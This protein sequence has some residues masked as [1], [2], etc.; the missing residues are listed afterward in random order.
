[1]KKHTFLRAFILSAA[2]CAVMLGLSISVS[3]GEMENE[4]DV[5]VETIPNIE[6]NMK[7]TD[8]E[9]SSLKEDLIN[10]GE[11]TALDIEMELNEE[12]EPADEAKPADGAEP[13]ED[14]EVADSNTGMDPE[15]SGNTHE[16]ADAVEGS[17]IIEGIGTGSE[18]TV[19]GEEEAAETGNTDVLQAVEESIDLQEEEAVD[20][21]EK[22][23]TEEV[24]AE[25]I[26]VEAAPVRRMALRSIL[27]TV[28]KT[29]GANTASGTVSTPAEDKSEETLN[30]AET[31]KK[32]GWDEIYVNGKYTGK[33]YRDT[34][35][36]PVSG[37]KQIDG[38]WYFF[39]PET[40]IMA[41]N[42]KYIDGFW[43]FF[44]SKTGVMAQNSFVNLD[45]KT[46][47]NGGPKTCYYD[48]Q[49]HLLY[50]QRRIG[51]YW[52]MFRPGSGAMVT[53]DFY[54]HDKY[55]NPNGGPKTCYYDAQGRLQYSQKKIGNYW[56][57]FRPGSGAMVEADFYNHD[58]NTNPNG[59][60][61][62]CYYDAHGRLQYSQKRIGNYWYMF[63]P[64]SGAMVTAD[65]YKH[66]NNTNP[67][68]GP[69]TCY[70]D[71]QG[72]LQYGQKRIGS[73][74]YMFRPG[75]GAMVEGDFFTHDSNTNP[76][77]GAKTCY[78]D[79]QGHMLYGVQVI[80][81]TTC[82]FHSS[83]G[84]LLKKI[85][86][87]LSEANWQVLTNV[88][89][90]VESGGQIYGNRDYAAYAGQY[91]SSSNEHTCTLGWAQNYGANAEE[92]I[93]RIYN[94][95]PSEFKQ[96]DTT[97]AIQKMIGK[98]WVGLR[99]DP[100]PEER[101]TLIRLITTDTGKKQQDLLF[102]DGCTTMVSDCMT[103]YSE[104]PKTIMMYCEVRHQGGNGG[105]TRIMNRCMERYGA[106]NVAN[107]LKSLDDD[108]AD[109]FNNQVGDYSRR[110]HV[111]A[112]FINKYTVV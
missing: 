25:E 64:G 110:H 27:S 62:T 31:T 108:L 92:L 19:T 2:A 38:K 43:Y 59:G 36:N 47:P 91:K 40:G 93:R 77:G 102:R 104:D 76:H 22:A 88:I 48:A 94:A 74:W 17:E 63:R 112:D 52:Y 50:N 41:T 44:D 65:F 78:Y 4:S 33:I 81:G 12:P 58:K 109:G 24:T 15:A 107:I 60:P 80:D 61:K 23:V 8:Q 79:A 83:S 105:V 28:P 16:P 29:T 98:D 35:G 97:G 99:W 86:R 75:S 103:R 11:Q 89:G 67:N 20:P 87:G 45:W 72:H 90:A 13:A 37:K 49:G 26:I 6:E 7:Y 95:N 30:S 56:Y 9:D 14:A 42:Q 1:M 10:D 46:N 70:Y 53:A 101:D 66:D 85:V 106:Y 21:A 5:S 34:N 18:D 39:D 111:C 3:A 84:A 100:N 73:Y 71:A 82:E 68:G 51:N 96:I 32:T 57:M 55:T 69:K 54:K